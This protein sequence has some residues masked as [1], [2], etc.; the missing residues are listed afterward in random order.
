MDLLIRPLEAND[1]AAWQ[2]LWFGYL[3]FYNVELAPEV[4]E[5][6]W[7]RLLDPNKDMHC[8]CALNEAGEMVGIVHYLFHPVT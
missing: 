6:T 7:R 8:L 5:T 4:T 2:P 3:E 1:R